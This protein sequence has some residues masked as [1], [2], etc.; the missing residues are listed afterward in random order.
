MDERPI[1]FRKAWRQGPPPVRTEEP[2]PA[3]GCKACRAP[4]CR[5]EVEIS[6]EEALTGKWR[7]TR[8]PDGAYLL[9]KKSATDDRCLYLGDDGKCTIYGDR[10]GLCSRFDCTGDGRFEYLK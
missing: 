8:A 10:P 5:L 9:A 7:F 4:C 3:N 1:W 6:K 2:L